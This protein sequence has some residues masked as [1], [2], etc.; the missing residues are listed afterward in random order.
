MLAPLSPV[1]SINIEFCVEQPQIKEPSSPFD[2]VAFNVDNGVVDVYRSIHLLPPPVHSPK[3]DRGSPTQHQ[4]LR[5]KGLDAARFEALK[6]SSKSLSNT[7]K[8]DLRKEVAMRAHQSKQSESSLLPR[9]SRAAF[10]VPAR[11]IGQPGKSPVALEISVIMVPSVVRGIHTNCHYGS[12]EAPTIL[13]ESVIRMNAGVCLFLS[14]LTEL[15]FASGADIVS[16]K[17]GL[18]ICICS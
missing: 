5:S 1:P 4:H 14:S 3:L 15:C 8:N 9:V 12:L 10:C 18:T 2:N 11:I 17:P 6:L 13:C 7:L 16:T